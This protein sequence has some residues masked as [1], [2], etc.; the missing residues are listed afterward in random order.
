[1]KQ[2]EVTTRSN[3]GGTLSTGYNAGKV[4]DHKMEGFMHVP[5]AAPES[6][7]DNYLEATGKHWTRKDHGFLVNSEV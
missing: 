4:I 2:S 1:M 7:I 3:L 5:I 6:E